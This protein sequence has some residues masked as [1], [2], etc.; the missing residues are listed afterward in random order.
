M[1]ESTAILPATHISSPWM[2]YKIMRETWVVASNSAYCL[3]THL[4]RCCSAFAHT[5]T[6]PTSLESR[7]PA[8]RP[9]PG[10]SNDGQAIGSGQAAASIHRIHHSNE[11]PVGGGATRLDMLRNLHRLLAPPSAHTIYRNRT[12][13]GVI[14]YWR[15]GADDAHSAPPGHSV[16][17]SPS[18]PYIW[19]RAHLCKANC[20]FSRNVPKSS[21]PYSLCMDMW[22]GLLFYR[23]PLASSV[24]EGGLLLGMAVGRTRFVFLVAAGW[25]ARAL[26]MAYIHI[27]ITA[28]LEN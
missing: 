1:L 8:L 21:Q 13:A 11:R 28:L 27:H 20:V 4:V 22:V 15:Q 9:E 10:A 7:C 19:P 12:R 18:M 26:H 16:T 14:N 25:A 23:R 6:S 3:L 24:C 5:P 2:Q 17:Y